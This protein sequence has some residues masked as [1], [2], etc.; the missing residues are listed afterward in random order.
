MEI[1]AVKILRPSI[2]VLS[3]GF[4]NKTRVSFGNNDDSDAYDQDSKKV[5]SGS[6]FLNTVRKW[7]MPLGILAN[8]GLGAFN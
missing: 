2:N 6:S 8:L 4:S 3:P 5:S 1:S 7:G